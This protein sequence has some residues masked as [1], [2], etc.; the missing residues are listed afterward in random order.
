MNNRALIKHRERQSTARTL[1]SNR[2]VHALD[3]YAQGTGD[4]S[5]DDHDTGRLTSIIDMVSPDMPVAAG[6]DTGKSNA[7]ATIK[8]AHGNS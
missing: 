4:E 1:H 2:E 8:P 5:H 6:K 3:F 7:E